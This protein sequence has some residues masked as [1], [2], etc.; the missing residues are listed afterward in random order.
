MNIDRIDD[1]KKLLVEIDYFIA[2]FY[3]IGHL[4]ESVNDIATNFKTQLINLVGLTEWMDPVDIEAYNNTIND[5][6]EI[7]SAYND[8]FGGKSKKRKSKKRKSRKSKKRKSRK[9]KRR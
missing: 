1:L 7:K 9:S 3:R 5:L 2:E 4:N 8:I 6:N